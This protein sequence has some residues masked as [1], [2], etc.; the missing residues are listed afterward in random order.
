MQPLRTV[1]QVLQAFL[2]VDKVEKDRDPRDLVPYEQLLID[3]DLCDYCGLCVPS[4]PEEAIA[5]E[6]EPLKLDE[7]PKIE[8]KIKVD[9]RPMYWLRQVRSGLPL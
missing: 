5:V 2:L 7:E 6:G 8:G 9:E 3:E 1:R 4:C